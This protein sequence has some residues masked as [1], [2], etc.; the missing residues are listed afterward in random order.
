MI[1]QC[2]AC[3]D[4]FTALQCNVYRKPTISMK[5]FDTCSS[6]LKNCSFSWRSSTLNSFHFSSI[7]KSVYRH[8]CLQGCISVNNNNNNNNSLLNCQMS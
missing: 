6:L 7:E 2:N 5:D 3:T 8:Y 4:A 1:D